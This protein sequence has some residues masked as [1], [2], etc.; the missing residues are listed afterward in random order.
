MFVNDQLAAYGK[1][2]L[3]HYRGATGPERQPLDVVRSAQSC[4]QGSCGAA[5]TLRTQLRVEA[6]VSSVAY[7]LSQVSPIYQQLPGTLPKW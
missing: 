7:I 4:L 6:F 2:L 5:R 3:T 1:A